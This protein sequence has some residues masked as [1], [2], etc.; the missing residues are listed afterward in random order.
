MT[1]RNIIRNIY[2]Y[3]VTL[4]GLVLIIIGTVDLIQMALKTWVFTLA[5]Q[6]YSYNT[7]PI[8][9]YGLK[10]TEPDKLFVNSSTALT[11]EDKQAFEQWKIDYK[12]W[13]EQNAKVDPKKAQKQT[14]AVRDISMLLVGLALFLSHGYIVRKDRKIEIEKN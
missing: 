5:D 8:A 7:M 11:V 14:D 1:T 3:V 12:A 4:I 13:Q 9:P 6:Q 10:T 2:L